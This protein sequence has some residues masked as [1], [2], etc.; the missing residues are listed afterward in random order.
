MSGGV[1]THLEPLGEI[2]MK[3]KCYTVFN[4]DFNGA[5]YIFLEL[6]ILQ[7]YKQ[8]CKIL[9]RAQ[10]SH[11]LTTYVLETVTYATHISYMVEF[12]L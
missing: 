12:N 7:S 4:T 6:T 11:F 5:I 10:T 1:I 9:G 8:S 3:I 2:L